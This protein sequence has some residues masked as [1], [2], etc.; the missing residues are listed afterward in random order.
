M[1]CKFSARYTAESA[2]ERSSNAIMSNRLALDE[3]SK[4]MAETRDCSNGSPVSKL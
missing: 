4:D 2:V 1:S 3:T